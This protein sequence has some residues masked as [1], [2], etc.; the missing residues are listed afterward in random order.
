[1]PRRDHH[2]QPQRRLKSILAPSRDTARAYAVTMARR[3]RAQDVPSR[4]SIRRRK[5]ARKSRAKPRAT[6]CR[7]CRRASRASR[8]SQASCVRAISDCADADRRSRGCGSPI[9]ESSR[10]LR[11]RCSHRRCRAPSSLVRVAPVRSDCS[12]R[13]RR[14]SRERRYPRSSSAIIENRTALEFASPGPFGVDYRSSTH[15]NVL[16]LRNRFS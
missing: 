1:M 4:T 7:A 16:H 13:V 11:R 3:D 12:P 8:R 2:A 5:A 10:R 9:S 15:G 14:R 6:Q